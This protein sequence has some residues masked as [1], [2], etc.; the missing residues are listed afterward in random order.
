[1]TSY[2][3]K[4]VSKCKA[5]LNFLRDLRYYH[6]SEVNVPSQEEFDLENEIEELE[7]RDEYGVPRW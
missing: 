4:L 2:K 1:M 5:E 6:G 3:E 7:N